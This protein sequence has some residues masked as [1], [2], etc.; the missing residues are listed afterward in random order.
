M[1]VRF[2]I[3][4]RSVVRLW[5]DCRRARATDEMDAAEAG[6]PGV[7]LRLSLCVGLIGKGKTTEDEEALWINAD[8]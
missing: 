5:T 3:E 4:A 8:C 1:L 2:P 6:D 7:R